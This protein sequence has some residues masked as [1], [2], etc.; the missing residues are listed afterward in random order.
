ME[1]IVDGYTTQQK[2]SCGSTVESVTEC[3]HAAASA[4][5]TPIVNTTGT[6]FGCRATLGA[7]GW[8]LEVGS[9]G[10]GSASVASARDGMTELTATGVS[11]RVTLDGTNATITLS[12]NASAWFGVGFNAKSMLDLPYAI[13]VDGTGAVSERKMANHA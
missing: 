5:L 8:S 11:V 6:G 1:K 12:G 10:C 4:G 2:G 9:T 13:I 7:N 3:A